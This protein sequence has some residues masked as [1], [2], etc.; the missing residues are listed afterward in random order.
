M[1][2]VGVATCCENL[3]F[4]EMPVSTSSS[5]NC[6][7][8]TPFAAPSTHMCEIDAKHRLD[9]WWQRLRPVEASGGVLFCCNASISP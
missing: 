3:I 1:G 9:W 7:N 2:V 4:Y 6:I 8:L 5:K